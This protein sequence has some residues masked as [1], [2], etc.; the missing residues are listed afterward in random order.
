MGAWTC[1]PFI[2][3]QFLLVGFILEAFIQFIMGYP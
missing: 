1:C 2:D 3:D